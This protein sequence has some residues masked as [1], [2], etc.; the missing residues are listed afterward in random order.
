MA[1]GTLA[2]LRQVPT[3]ARDSARGIGMSPWQLLARV[4]LPL[5]LPVFLS[6]LRVTTVQA[7]GL[8]AVAALIGAGGFGA[9]LFQGLSASAPDQTLLGV[10][11]IA[12]LAAA[13]DAAFKIVIS[14]MDHAA[15]D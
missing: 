10:L 12:L 8:A 14:R 5:A 6:G 2:A 7:V 15:H 9:I 11:P 1:H 4:E 3:A 13:C